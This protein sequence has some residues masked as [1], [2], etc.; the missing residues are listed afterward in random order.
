VTAF[1]AAMLVTADFS[2]AA[3]DVKKGV[4]QTAHYIYT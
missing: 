3:L 1:A 2:T 4:T